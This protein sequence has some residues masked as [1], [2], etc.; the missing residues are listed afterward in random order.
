MLTISKWKRGRRRADRSSEDLYSAREIK[1]KAAISRLSDDDQTGPEQQIGEQKALMVRDK[2]LFSA[3]SKVVVFFL[4]R[5]AGVN[6]GREV[7]RSAPS[8]EKREAS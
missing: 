8:N 1:E 5:E 6:L 7:H 4:M 3:V 2:S